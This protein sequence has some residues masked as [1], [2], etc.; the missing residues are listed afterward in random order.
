MNGME[1]KQKRNR[2]SK[3][4]RKAKGQRRR[5]RAHGSHQNDPHIG[6][7]GGTGDDA[8]EESGARMKYVE[9]KKQQF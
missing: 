4:E 5:Y 6:H 1:G 7:G 2:G 9:R 8:A 3:G